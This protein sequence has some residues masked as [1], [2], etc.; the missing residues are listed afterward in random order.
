MFQV[1]FKHIHGIPVFSAEILILSDQQIA[2]QG[3]PTEVWL[4]ANSAREYGNPALEPQ[5]TF[6]M[7]AEQILEL[8]EHLLVI[9]RKAV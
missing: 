4:L 5:K 1:P 2:I 3:T 8:H 6:K 7:F 9:D